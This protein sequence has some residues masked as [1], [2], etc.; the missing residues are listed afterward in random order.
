WGGGV[1][2]FF[3]AEDGIGDWSVTGVQTCALPISSLALVR[4]GDPLAAG[5]RRG[6]VPLP[7]RT[8]ARPPTGAVRRA[9]PASAGRLRVPL[10]APRPP[11]VAPGIRAHQGE[12]EMTAELQ[13]RV[14]I[15][16]S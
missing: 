16:A 7:P 5:A 4:R 13:N 9:D 10:R 3:K 14:H 12:A 2:F 8:V 6:R 1:C 11:H 15:A